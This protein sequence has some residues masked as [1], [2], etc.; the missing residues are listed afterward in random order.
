[1]SNKFDIL[2]AGEIN[3]DLILTGD[4]IPTFDQVEKLV[5][6]ARLVIGSS[7]AIFAC[8]AAR[9]GLK[10]A[11]TGISGSDIFGTFMIDEMT[12]R[13]VDV[14]SVRV[15]PQR[16]TGLSVILTKGNDRAILTHTG[17]IGDLRSENISDDLLHRCRHLHIASYYLQTALQPGL[18]DLFQRAH[19][20]GLT[21]SLDTNWDPAGKWSGARELLPLCDIFLPNENEA[22]AISQTRTM[23]QA[24]KW[25]GERTNTVA[26]KRGSKGALAWHDG[27]TTSSCSLST[28]VIDTVGAGDTFDAGFVY[29]FL[30][31]WAIEKTLC[32][33]TVCGSLSTQAAGGT[34]GQP[35]LEEAMLHVSL[36]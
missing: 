30:K 23:G 22:I 13:G 10:V 21:T 16:E 36:A 8:G 32:F 29:G 14:S 28:T 11:F 2:V 33:A 7:S 25:L 5:D 17:S 9:L 35:T 6:S 1:M 19:G 31:G 3:P 20:F 12:K 15:D 26:L 4:V 27:Q 24:L 34:E 18:P